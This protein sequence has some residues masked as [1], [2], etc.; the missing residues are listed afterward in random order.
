MLDP[1]TTDLLLAIAHHLL[2]FALFAILLIEAL[3]IRPGMQAPF[4]RRM[5]YLDRLYGTTAVLVLAVG[6]SRVLFGAK[7]A[8]FYLG[9]PLFWAKIVS[10]AAVAV[11]SIGPTLKLIEWARNSRADPLFTPPAEDMRKVR[12]FIAGELAVFPLILIFAA[13]MARGFGL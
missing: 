8:L 13:A 9:N 12:R 11:L 6:T 2:I 7:G 4:I 10:F 1:M 3:L 5:T